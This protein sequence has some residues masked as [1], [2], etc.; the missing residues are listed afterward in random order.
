M[1]VEKSGKSGGSLSTRTSDRYPPMTNDHVRVTRIDKIAT[2]ILRRFLV[3]MA[4]L[5]AW[6]FGRQT[7]NK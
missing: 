7:Q 3:L 1:T 2:A 4:I 6:I 5:I